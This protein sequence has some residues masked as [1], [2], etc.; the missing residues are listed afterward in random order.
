MDVLLSW[1]TMGWLPSHREVRTTDASK[2]DWDAVWR[3]RGKWS[4]R[5]AREHINLLGLHAVRLALEHF[6]PVLKDR[7]VLVL[8]GNLSTVFYVNHYGGNR[9]R[10]TTSTHTR[11]LDMG[12]PHVS[13][14]KIDIPVRREQQHSGC[15]IPPCLKPRILE[16][17]PSRGQEDMMIVQRGTRQSTGTGRLPTH[18][19]H[20]CA[21]GP[22]P[23]GQAP[24]SPSGPPVAITNMVSPV[25]VSSAGIT[26]GAF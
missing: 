22:G 9:S 8:S 5:T 12:S 18:S 7:H 25:T 23:E 14:G 17:T 13:V 3:H 24:R 4:T 1:V 15:L 20:P 11:T 6:L 19:C 2:T 16:A 10:G 21:A 26:M